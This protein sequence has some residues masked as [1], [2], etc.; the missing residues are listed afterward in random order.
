MMILSR[1]VASF[2]THI[3]VRRPG[4]RGVVWK[5]SCYAGLTAPQRKR[6]R[7]REWRRSVLEAQSVLAEN[8][9]CLLTEIKMTKMAENV[10]KT[11]RI[12]KKIN[13]DAEI[14]G[15]GLDL[16]KLSSRIG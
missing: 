8:R 9:P 5:I 11:R 4:F 3:V 7:L 12:A 10:V 6:P 14:S 16:P 13:K 15:F 2:R 1:M